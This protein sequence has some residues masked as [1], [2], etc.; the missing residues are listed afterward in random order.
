MSF[1]RTQLSAGLAR[2]ED[3]VQEI[4]GMAARGIGPQKL[5]AG[6]G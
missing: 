3:A 6:T 4:A 2:L 5:L 1:S